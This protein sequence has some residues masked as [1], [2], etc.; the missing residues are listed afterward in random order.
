[1]SGVNENIQILGFLIFLKGSL[2]NKYGKNT[3]E[4]RS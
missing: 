2:E 4:N 1:M 3:D